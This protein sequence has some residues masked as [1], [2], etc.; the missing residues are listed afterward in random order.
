MQNMNQH[1]KRAITACFSVDHWIGGS[2]WSG[3]VSTQ[4]E[5]APREPSLLS[6]A[7]KNKKTLLL[8]CIQH[9]RREV[10]TWPEL[11]FP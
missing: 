7:T 6:A 11:T 1:G 8:C 9:W 5:P 4:R 2:G 10:D 3:G